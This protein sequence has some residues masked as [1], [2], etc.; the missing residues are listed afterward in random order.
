MRL[1]IVFAHGYLQIVG[2]IGSV[3]QWKVNYNTN[4]IRI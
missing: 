4:I 1:I 2:D 3:D